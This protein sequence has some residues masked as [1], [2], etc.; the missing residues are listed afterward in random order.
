MYRVLKAVKLQCSDIPEDGLRFDIRGE[1]GRWEGL[2]GFSVEARPS[3]HLLV[4]KRG[5]NV[6]VQGEVGTTLRFVCSRCLEGFPYQ[7]QT[8]L[9][10][11]LRPKGK[12][13]AETKEIKLTQDDLACDTYDGEELLLDSIVEE[14]LLLSLPM[15]P[16][17]DQ[18]CRGLCPGCGG[19]RNRGEC[20]CPEDSRKTPFDCLKDF[21]VKER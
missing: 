13:S 17:C 1:D 4:Q 11:L 2:K 8:T 6:F 7:V 3:G 9:S 14:H 10:Q 18:D 20:A 16:L 5:R 12:D 21:V 15:R 19:N